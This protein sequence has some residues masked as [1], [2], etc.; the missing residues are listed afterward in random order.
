MDQSKA[1]FI[2]FSSLP[3]QLSHEARG[4]FLDVQ[5]GENLFD[6]YR[7]GL[8]RFNNQ[9]DGVTETEFTN[10]ALFKP[11]YY[12]LWGK[13]DV[14]AISEI[15]DLEFA[16][17]FFRPYNPIRNSI[18]E[19]DIDLENFDYKVVTG[20]N[21]LASKGYGSTKLPYIAICQLK[22]NS[23]FLI[24]NGLLLVSQLAKK[25]H[26][27]IIQN[28]EHQRKQ[29]GQDLEVQFTISESFSY[30]EFV[31]VLHSNSLYALKGIISI[32]R[33]FQVGE[34]KDQIYQSIL[35]NSIFN[36]LI[37]EQ[38][39]HNGKISNHLYESTYTTFGV[40]RDFYDKPYLEWDGK[41]VLN[42]N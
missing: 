17:R 37:N 22:I 20:F 9:I 27:T 14:C 4:N 39:N 15:D 16:T 31:I 41:P 13:Y 32:I 1:F 6:E 11:S 18:R 19:N 12:Y 3:I 28:V 7:K 23:A 29:V 38:E 8:L 21:P 35:D 36:D 10:K 40:S 5:I 42:E 33:S 34:L 24:G 25:V 26:E 30:Y 2:G